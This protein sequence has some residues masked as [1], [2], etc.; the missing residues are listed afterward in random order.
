MTLFF[1]S[2]T[3]SVALLTLNPFDRLAPETEPDRSSSKF[4]AVVTFAPTSP[5]IALI[6]VT[7]TE[8]LLTVTS[9]KT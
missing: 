6:P 4:C 8:G 2:N 7:G 5:G 3:W 1:A 9:G